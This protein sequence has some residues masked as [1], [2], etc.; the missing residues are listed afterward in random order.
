MTIKSILFVLMIFLFYHLINN[1]SCK[2]SFNGFQ[3]VGSCDRAAVTTCLKTRNCVGMDLS[4][5]NLSGVNLERANLG[6]ANLSG[7]NLSGANL[8]KTFL[9]MVNLSNA[10]AIGTDL[11][12]AILEAA[13]LTNTNLTNANLGSADLRDADLTGATL[14]NANLKSV[15]NN[16]I[17]VKCKDTIK[18]INTASA[19]SFGN[20]DDSETPASYECLDGLWHRCAKEENNYGHSVCKWVK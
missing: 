13:K 2:N 10:T 1:C 20:P 17:D 3:N 19:N 8:S 4:N 11:D 9:N 6:K 18:G 15:I 14:T 12:W 7:S 5:C 16:I